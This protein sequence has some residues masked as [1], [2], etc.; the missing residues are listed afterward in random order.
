MHKRF[1]L[2]FAPE[3]EGNPSSG[4]GGTPADPGRFA[5]IFQEMSGQGAV[6]GVEDPTK[7]VEQTPGQGGQPPPKVEQTPAWSLQE[8]LAKAYPEQPD[9]LRGEAQIKNWKEG[10]DL[11]QKSLEASEVSAKRAAELEAELER[12]RASSATPMVETEAVKKLQTELEQSRQ[13]FANEKKELEEFRAR[14]DLSRNPEFQ[15]AYD[16]SR[17]RIQDSMGETIREAKL[18]E[19]LSEKL[20]GAK[21]EYEIAKIL[22]GVEDQTAAKLLGEHSREFLRLTREREAAL[23]GGSPVD[24]LQ[25]W[26]DYEAGFQDQLSRQLRAI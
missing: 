26:R 22:E 10:R 7:K 14:H 12:I 13:Q 17:A 24:H 11:I 16:G 21:S 18:S 3:T 15:R 19:D 8:F 1:F 4:G 5:A 20:I 2:L 23:N 6:A 25:S 9:F